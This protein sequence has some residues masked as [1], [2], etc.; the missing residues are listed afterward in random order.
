MCHDGT[1]AVLFE[2]RF[3]FYLPPLIPPTCH[4][5]SPKAGELEVEAVEIGGKTYYKDGN[6]KLYVRCT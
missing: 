5:A 4:H 6:D 2:H 3:S 1:P